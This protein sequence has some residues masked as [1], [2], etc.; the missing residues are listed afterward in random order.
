MEFGCDRFRRT[1][2]E[3]D[4]RQASF[5]DRQEAVGGHLAQHVADARFRHFVEHAE[6]RQAFGVEIA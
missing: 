1:G 2:S 3:A 5:R 6:R 4:D